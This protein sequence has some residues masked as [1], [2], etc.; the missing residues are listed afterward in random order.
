MAAR[1]AERERRKAS[2]A[3]EPPEPCMPSGHEGHH[4]H[5]QGNG[6]ICSCGH[7]AGGVFSY[8]PDPRFWSDDPAERAQAEREETDWQAWISCRIC[9]AP[10][11]TAEDVSWPPR[12]LTPPRS[13]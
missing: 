6:M 1:A 4:W 2:A 13:A 3:P 10:G 5:V 8:M 12:T 11:V 9:G 7:L